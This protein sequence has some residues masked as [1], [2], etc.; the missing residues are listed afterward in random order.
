M[1]RHLE[2]EIDALR[3]KLLSV[4]ALVEE[5]GKMA[6]EALMTRD[7]E[8]AE[9]VI[10]TDE[11]I[12][13]MEVEVEEECLKVLAL[14]QP[15][16][17]DLRYVVAMLKINNDLERIG[18]IAT[19]IAERAI[20]LSHRVKIDIP[21]DFVSMSKL[22]HEMVRDSLDSL[23]YLDASLARKVCEMDD[24]VD[25]CNRRVYDYVKQQLLL[26]TTEIMEQVQ[27]LTVARHI[28][29]IGDQATNI[30]EDVLYLIE[31]EIVRHKRRDSY[32]ATPE[33]VH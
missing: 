28:E 21:Q 1:R 18:D 17:I 25:E 24:K 13:Q 15:V 23:V 10:E 7:V 19:N 6:I 20:Y 29:R 16:A 3:K 26:G 5:A 2:R 27:L 14:H 8:L 22:A 33:E 31:G 4:G 30:A 12:D 11:Q 32:E 9:R